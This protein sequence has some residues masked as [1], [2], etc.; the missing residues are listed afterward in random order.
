MLKKSFLIFVVALFGTLA[1]HAGGFDGFYKKFGELKVNQ[2]Y[3]KT[4]KK[5]KKMAK[6]FSYYA[7][8]QEVKDALAGKKIDGKPVVVIDSRTKKE[9]AG[10]EL[11]G[12]THANLRGWNKSFESKNM[13]SNNIGAI[14]NYCRTGTDVAGSIVNLEWLFQGKGKIFG[15]KDM[16]QA[17]YPTT[18]KSG[19]VLDAK[20]NVKHVFV[21]KAK[22]G[23]YYEVN[24]QEVKD[25]CSPV[26][27]F[28]KGD[29][30]FMKGDNEKLPMTFTAKS[31]KLNKKV[32][33]YKGADDRYYRK[34]CLEK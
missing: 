13:H 27:V 24:C 30:D 32:T 7:S 19:N 21:Q 28:T 33:L 4:N 1:L 22:N 12:V 18:S 14:Y 20:L 26:D 8:V 31:K 16:V 9:Q 15:L 23:S 11:K 6:K 17:C 5:I 2:G 3:E 10:L 25:S 29:I 34:G